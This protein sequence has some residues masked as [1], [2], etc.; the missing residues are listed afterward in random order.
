MVHTNLSAGL[1]LSDLR[2]DNVL[3][4]EKDNESFLILCDFEQRGNW[5]EW[6]PPEILYPQYVENLRK[7]VG[8]FEGQVAPWDELIALYNRASLPK[9][10]EGCGKVA[11]SNWPW[12]VLTSEQQE[13]A[14]VFLIGLMMYCIFEGLSNVRLNIANKYRHEDSEVQFPRF[15][16]TPVQ[17]QVLIK[18]YTAGAPEW[19]SARAF[20]EN[21]THGCPRRN[22]RVVQKDD[23][24]QTEGWM[25]SETEYDVLET[26][27]GWWTAELQRAKW[28]F[29]TCG[30]C[31]RDAGK[32]RPTLEQ[33]LLDVE[34]LR[35]TG[36]E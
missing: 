11:D 33:V 12:F 21:Q 28:F 34:T 23:Q 15:L 31:Y 22:R 14:Q 13:K 4:E 30:D 36:F 26:G 2:P 1:F 5:H 29:E 17:V 10:R 9:V 3:L 20:A 19:E 27:L 24:L 35:Q 25:G 16:R 18:R 8:G 7:E 32:T 6:C